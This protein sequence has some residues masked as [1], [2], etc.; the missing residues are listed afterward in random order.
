MVGLETAMVAGLGP[1][2]SVPEELAPEGDHVY[3]ILFDGPATLKVVGKPAQTEFEE[4]DGVK[5]R[6][7][8]MLTVVVWKG[9]I[10]SV[11]G[12]VQPELSAVNA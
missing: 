3:E 10:G 9:L 7:G 8:L 5:E 4:A 2:V 11:V 12:L 1:G 6:T